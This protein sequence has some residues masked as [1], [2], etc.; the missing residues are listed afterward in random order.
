MVK[1][2]IRSA[3]LAVCAFAMLAGIIE[4][5]TIKSVQAAKYNSGYASTLLKKIETMQAE[6]DDLNK[7]L[8]ELEAEIDNAKGEISTINDQIMLLDREIEYQSAL[9]AHYETNVEEMR[10]RLNT[11]Q[12]QEKSQYAI[13][14]ESVRAMEESNEISFWRVLFD[15]NSMPELIERMEMVN[16][17]A[18]YE[19]EQLEALQNKR[20]EIATVRYDLQ[21]Q[22][23]LLTI[24]LNDLENERKQ[25]LEKSNGLRDLVAE[26]STEKN[27]IE[28][29]LEYIVPE[30]TSAIS[31]STR[32]DPLT[33]AEMEDYIGKARLQLVDAGIG[34]DE[35][36]ERLGTLT[37]GLTLVGQVPYFWGGRSYSPGWN[38]KW[39]TMQPCIIGGSSNFQIGVEYPYGLDCSGFVFWCALT[40]Y[41]ADS[42]NS[43]AEW[44]A[45]KNAEHIFAAEQ[46]EKVD[47]TQKLPG[48]IVVNSDRSHIGYYLCTTES[49]AELYLHC[50]P[51]G[52]PIVSDRSYC[53]FTSAAKIF[54][55][56]Q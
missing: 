21:E 34:D 33:D 43:P 16:T 29:Q 7:R 11:V 25:L 40:M 12:A 48:D 9:V 4:F 14:K 45:S 18:S 6:K 55:K 41:G 56:A 27:N 3:I 50:S 46:S 38:N 39:L 23:A 49:G 22:E 28:L 13:L 42:W 47:W 31:T 26:Y 5:A 17:I 53:S 32:I 8:I 36:A 54:G 52:G 44:M 35:I 30:L 24:A 51:L 2:K 19:K 37:H 15:A 20:K 10:K 1:H